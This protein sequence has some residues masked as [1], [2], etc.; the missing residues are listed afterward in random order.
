MF[1][2]YIFYNVRSYCS[3][4]ANRVG[5]YRIGGP[6]EPESQFRHNS[7]AIEPPRC[8]S[9][10]VPAQWQ[11]AADR[12]HQPT[13]QT[14]AEITVIQGSHLRSVP[15]SLSKEP[16]PRGKIFITTHRP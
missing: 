16:I 15:R 5:E 6:D 12:K 9:G 10:S 7:E 14:G 3:R 13:A 1:H 11:S 4:V 2:S 8:P